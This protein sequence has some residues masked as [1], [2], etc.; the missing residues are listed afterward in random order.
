MTQEFLAAL[1][2]VFLLKVADGDEPRA[3]ANSKLVLFRGPLHT[4]SSAVD[5]ED[6]QG[7]LPRPLLQGPHIGITVGAAGDNAVAVWSPVNTCREIN[8]SS[9]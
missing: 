3:T 9:V 1:P 5:P 4:A 2:V 8:S 6:D 7:G